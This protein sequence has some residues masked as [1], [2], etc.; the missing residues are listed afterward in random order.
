M[1]NVALAQLVKAMLDRAL[2]ALAFGCC[3]FDGDDVKNVSVV[4]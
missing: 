1:G 2:V 3:G 4:L